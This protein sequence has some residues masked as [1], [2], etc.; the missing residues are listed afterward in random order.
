VNVG[1]MINLEYLQWFP[2]S[3]DW[4]K[5]MEKWRLPIYI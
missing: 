2:E 5:K 3:L 1:F 4:K